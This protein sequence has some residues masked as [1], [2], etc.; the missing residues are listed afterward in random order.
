MC[1]IAQN[2]KNMG[3]SINGTSASPLSACV[4]IQQPEIEIVPKPSTSLD[5]QL[6]PAPVTALGVVLD[7][8]VRL[9]AEPLRDGPVLPPS[10]CENSFCAE[11]LLGRHC[12][13]RRGLDG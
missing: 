13:R 11:S 5:V 3:V 12:R 4:V 1:G 10:L 2:E 8:G 9:K 6:G 7:F